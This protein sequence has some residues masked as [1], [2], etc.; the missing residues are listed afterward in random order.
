[1][2][3][4]I[5]NILI[6]AV[7]I[8]LAAVII[9]PRLN[10]ERKDPPPGSAGAPGA[11]KGSMKVSGYVVKA[12]K[13]DNIIRTTGTVL[14][15]EDVDLVA[16]TS[17]R[18]IKIYF[19]E[20]GHINKGDL[21]IKIN[22]EDLQA[23]LKKT[24]LQIKLGEEQ[25]KRQQE[26]LKI[27]ATSQEEYDI[28]LNQLNTL[29][30][31]KDVLKAAINKTE[32]RAPFNGIIG[33]KYVNEGSYVSSLTKIASVQ[34][35][36]PVKIDFSIP[37]KYSG[38]VSIGD[39]VSFTNETSSQHFRGKVFAIEPKIDLST[40][41]LQ[42]RAICDNKN[43]KILP[44]SFAKINLRLKETSALMI[45]TQAL[46]PVLKGQTVFI[47]K[48]GVAQSIYVRTGTRTDTKIEV[49]EGL[50]EGDTLITTG[51]NSLKPNTP[52]TVIFKKY[53]NNY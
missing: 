44:G 37:E 15:F 42:L 11:A 30:A 49:A 46:I 36:N 9:I 4:H 28:I 32:I 27:S 20:G 51:M 29:K 7:V 26:L 10:S 40:R 21:L 24:E 19:T 45:P 31:D 16:E 12:E 47:C 6:I 52:V 5:K 17:G 1:M 48:D 53:N 2:S 22:D 43:E 35:I 38:S 8:I 39:D 3:R 25:E 18:I 41:T 14:A 33:L 23:Q 50:S 13:L 34:N